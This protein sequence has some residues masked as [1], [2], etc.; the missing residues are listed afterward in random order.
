MRPVISNSPIL[1]VLAACLLLTACTTTPPAQVFVPPV[2]PPPPDQPRFVYERTLLYNDDVEEYTSTDRLKQFALG[3]SRKLRGLI[4]PY[5]VAVNKGRVYVTDTV[6][7]AVFMFDIPGRRFVEFGTEKPGELAKP[8]GIDIANSGD[9]YVADISAKRVLVYSAEGR[10]LRNIGSEK[11]LA[12]P[13]DVTVSPDGQQ[14][15]VVDT[16][17]IDSPNHDVVVYDAQDGHYLRTIGRRGIGKGEFNLPLQAATAPDG[18]LYVVDSGNFRVQI[19]SPEGDFLDSFGSVGRAPGQFARAKGI[20]IDRDGRIYV[21]DTAFG[22]VQIFDPQTRLLMFIGERGEAGYPGKFMLPAG[23]DVDPDGRIY[24]V[25]QFFRKVDVFRP[26]TMK[27]ES[28]EAAYIF[29]G[30][31]DE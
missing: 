7:R 11:R 3:A 26:A 20:A 13:S 1:A 2:Y 30:N 22:N 23:I 29:K 17:G 21:V 24:M 16:G 8:M 18:R 5:D 15:Y 19:F 9:V 28:G 6:Q 27:A 12:R 31:P 25:D 10:Y 4:K 14:I